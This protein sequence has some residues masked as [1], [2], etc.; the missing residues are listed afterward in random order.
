MVLV[1][2]SVIW[3]MSWWGGGGQIKEEHRGPK[4]LK[5]M[6]YGPGIQQ[7]F[8]HVLIASSFFP[9]LIDWKPRRSFC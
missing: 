1:S 7:M 2:S 9:L 4:G 5:V 3:A 8:R 6:I